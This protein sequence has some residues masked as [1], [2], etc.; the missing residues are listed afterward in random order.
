LN[1]RIFISIGLSLVIHILILGLLKSSEFGGKQPNSQLNDVRLN[2]YFDNHD[3]APAIDKLTIESLIPHQVVANISDDVSKPI[4]HE[5]GSNGDDS[6]LQAT[7]HYYKIKELDVKPEM[8]GEINTKPTE[9]ASYKQGGEVKIQIWIDE[10]GNVIK[11]E[12]LDSDLPEA[13]T[14]YTIASFNQAKFTA[15][16]KE[17]VPVKAIAKVVVQY[18]AIDNPE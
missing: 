17:G 2:V 9:L 10:Q 15:G 18:T 8:I 12:V 7:A 13:F 6:L 4:Q 16:I 14:N 3:P 5:I 1:Q 11:S